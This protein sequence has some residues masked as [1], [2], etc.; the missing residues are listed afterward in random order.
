MNIGKRVYQGTFSTVDVEVVDV[1][2][3]AAVVI[4]I[5]IIGVVG[6]K[7]KFPPTGFIPRRV[8]RSPTYE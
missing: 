1:I 6:K 5:V 8:R 2:G 3:V 4:V 7:S